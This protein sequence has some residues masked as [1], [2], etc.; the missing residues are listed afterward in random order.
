MQGRQEDGSRIVRQSAASRNRIVRR[1]QPANR[2]TFVSA[3]RSATTEDVVF[4]ES[5]KHDIIYFCHSTP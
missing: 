4:R 1:S 3:S 5:N 2:Q